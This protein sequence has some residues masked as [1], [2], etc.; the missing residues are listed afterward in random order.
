MF[1]SEFVVALIPCVVWPVFNTIAVLAILFPVSDIFSSVKMLIS[2]T[3]LSFVIEPVTLIDVTIPMDESTFTVGL[4]IFPVADV[5]T[6]VLPDLGS[7]T[8]SVAVLDPL[9]MIDGAIVKLIR[10]S[11]NERVLSW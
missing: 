10:S 2:A 1:L 5:L 6:A 7:L 11:V 8:L 9:A 4:V 3:S